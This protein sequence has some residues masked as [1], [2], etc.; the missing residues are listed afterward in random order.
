MKTSC[1]AYK[2]KERE[3]DKKNLYDFSTIFSISAL[4]LRMAPVS[5]TA[6]MNILTEW[7]VAFGS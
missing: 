7:G 1:C 2:T 3:C 5:P 4:H 6:I